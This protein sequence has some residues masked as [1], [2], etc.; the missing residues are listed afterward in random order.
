MTETILE[1]QKEAGFVPDG[2]DLIKVSERLEKLDISYLATMHGS[3]L[4]GPYIKKLLKAWKGTAD[5]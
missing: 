3:T 5:V 1:F 2:E 4:K